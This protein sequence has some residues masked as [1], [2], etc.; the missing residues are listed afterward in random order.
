MH[1]KNINSIDIKKKLFWKIKLA[2]LFHSLFL[3]QLQSGKEYYYSLQ[4]LNKLA[5]FL[6]NSN[7]TSNLIVWIEDIILTSDLRA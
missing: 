4:T 6:D 5:N 3:G 2:T 7:I 1:K